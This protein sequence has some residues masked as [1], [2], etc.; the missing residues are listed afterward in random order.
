VNVYL[1]FSAFNINL[2]NTELSPIF[3]LLALLGSHL[4]FHVSRIKVKPLLYCRFIRACVFSQ[5]INIAMDRCE[6]FT[7]LNNLVVSM[8]VPPLISIVHLYYLYSL[9]WVDVN[10]SGFDL[11]QGTVSEIFW[12]DW[13]KPWK[14][15][16]RSENIVRTLQ[17]M[18]Q[19]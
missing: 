13:S 19:E 18:Q 7:E 3:H 8:R 10:E 16:L 9:E 12:R 17:H 1:V 14:I 6:L 2:L 11:V 5:Q 4:I 15:C